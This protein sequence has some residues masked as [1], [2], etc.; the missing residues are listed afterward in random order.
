MSVP[1]LI[2]VTGSPC[3]GKSTLAR[4]LSRELSLP[5]VSKDGI[6]ETLFDTLGFSDRAWSRRLGLSSYALLYYFVELQL[7]AGRSLIVES[8]FHAPTAGPAFEALRA[9]Y[10]FRVVQVFCRTEPQV[11]M[12]RFKTRA[13]TTDRHP[14]HVELQNIDEF[15]A[16][17]AAEACAPIPLEGK[18]ITLDTTD[19]ALVDYKSVV[20]E[21]RAEERADTL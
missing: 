6:K 21:I 8:N 7:A 4:F 3:T 10:P 2:I 17:L 9:K 12:E 20:E 1:I 15:R 13:A 19:F 11:L 16:A 5:M 18:L 14:G